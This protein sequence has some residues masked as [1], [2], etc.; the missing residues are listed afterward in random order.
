[1]WPLR[2]LKQPRIDCLIEKTSLNLLE[3]PYVGS[4]REQLA[5]GLRVMFQGRYAIYYLPADAELT[6]VRVLHGARDVAAV[7]ERGDLSA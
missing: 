1:M 6:I 4:P 5:P 7:E 2:A 3:L